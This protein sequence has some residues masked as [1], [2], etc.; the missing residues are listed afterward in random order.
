MQSFPRKWVY[1]C[2]FN[3]TPRIDHKINVWQIATDKYGRKYWW[4]IVTYETKWVEYHRPVEKFAYCNI[5]DIQ[6]NKLFETQCKKH[7]SQ[8]SETI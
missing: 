2:Y 1:D 8:K 6:T 4:N 7:A 3:S 5:F